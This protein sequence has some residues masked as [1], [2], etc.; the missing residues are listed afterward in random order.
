MLFTL[1]FSACESELE[2]EVLGESSFVGI[3]NMKATF[4]NDP[5]TKSDTYTPYWAVGEKIGLFMEHEG[6]VEGPMPF[7]IASISGVI[8][9]QESV[10]FKD[11]FSKHVFYAYHPYE[12]NTSTNPEEVQVT[13]ISAVQVQQG[14]SSNHIFDYEYNI[15]VP[16]VC[17]PDEDLMLGFTSTY[18]FFEFQFSGNVNGI[19]VTDVNLKAEDTH[20][21][22]FS[23]ATTNITL[24]LNDPNFARY[25][26]TVGGNSETHLEI[27]GGLPVPTTDYAPAYM[28]FNPFDGTDETLKITVAYTYNGK[29]YIK[30]VEVSAD[31]YNPGSRYA[32][33]IYLEIESPQKTIKNIKVLSICEVGSLGTCDN[34]KKWNCYYGAKDKHAKE[35]RRLLFEHFGKGKTVETG[36]ISFEKVEHKHGLNKL[37]KAYLNKFNIIYLNNNARPNIQMS[38]MIMEWLDESPDRVLM[39]A[40]DWK[41]PKITPSSRESDV[42]CKITTNYLIFRDHIYGVT[43][44]WYNGKDNK[45]I[46]NYGKCRQDMLIPF[47]LN[48]ETSYFWK[49]GPFKTNLKEGSDLRYWVEDV[50][51]GSAEVYDPN[52]IQ[53]ITYRDA[54]DDKYHNKIHCKGAGDGGMVLGVDPVRRIVYIGDSELFSVKCV[55]SKQKEARMSEEGTCK[56]NE[57]NNFS[58]VMGNL[59]AWMIDE[60]IQKN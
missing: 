39:L 55:G 20:M 1:L 16:T 35:I 60:V 24:P 44:H 50:W 22:N 5:V 49:D 51:W 4:L 29:D 9:F 46:G 48:A 23:S 33:P 12:V 36:V 47:E 15:A 45:S 18:A 13:P 30:D 14:T 56:P 57:M 40:Y 32:I 58:K 31:V 27:S 38:R 42:I 43:P 7:T 28:V 17:Y 26:N 59:W 53:L 11:D 34:T 6:T 19:T 25:T 8:Q 3:G 54:R 37:T 52:V 41:D 21:I 10:P 2:K